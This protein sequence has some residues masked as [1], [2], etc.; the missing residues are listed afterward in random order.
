MRRVGPG[1]HRDERGAVTV[2]AVALIG[3]L[4]L[5]TAAFGVVEAMV[6]AHRRAQAAADLA[7]LAGAQAIEHGGQACAAATSVAVA[8]GARMAACAIDG[9]DVGVTVLVAGPRWLGAHGDLPA[10]ARAGPASELAAT[11]R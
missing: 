4:V 3:V 8:N 2:L 11:S 6:A 5:L 10:R 7:A 1:R 9:R